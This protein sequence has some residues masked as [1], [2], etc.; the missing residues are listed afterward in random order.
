LINAFAVKILMYSNSSTK[1]ISCRRRIATLQKLSAA[2]N[3]ALSIGIDLIRFIM[4]LGGS[5]EK[6]RLITTGAAFN[7]FV[8]PVT[9]SLKSR[10]NLNN[11]MSSCI[12]FMTLFS[13]RYFIIGRFSFLFTKELLLRFSFDISCSRC[14]GTTMCTM[15]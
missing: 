4:W 9:R 1:C 15:S 5:V 3:R 12:K 14:P 6:P 13:Q 7:P 10:R 8:Y 11:R 2:N